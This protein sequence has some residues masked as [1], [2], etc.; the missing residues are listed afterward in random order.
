VIVGDG[1]GV[2]VPVR[3]F[4]GGL[5]RLAGSVPDGRRADLARRW[6]HQVVI[7]AGDAPVVVVSSAPEVASW[8]RGLGLDVLADPGRGLDAAASAGRDALADRGCVRAVIAHA[9]LPRARSLAPVAS[10]GN[11]LVVALVPC[12]RDD[13]T[14][15]LAVPT[16]VPFAF[17]YGAGSFRRHVAEGRR[18][19]L[20]VRVVRDR[21]LAF[22]VDLP[23]DL[24]RLHDLDGQALPGRV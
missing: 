12:H 16:S 1:V 4:V 7:A 23:A 3:G 10:D 14:P 13:G 15:V 2:V 22:D 8:A 18:L 20:D 11:A 21:E 5:A 6:A 17:S 24:A 9:D 19:G